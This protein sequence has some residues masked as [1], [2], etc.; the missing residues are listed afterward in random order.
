MHIG[1]GPNDPGT[2]A[3]FVA[4]IDA[5]V[6]DFEHCAALLDPSGAMGTFGIDLLVSA[7]GG[8]P[9]T[10]NVRTVLSGEDFKKCMVAAFQNVEFAHP[11]HGKT[12]L[13][14]SVRIGPR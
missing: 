7:G 13:S 14:Y 2:K 8:H 12:K 3:P 11:K 4:A 5:R 9:Q 1:G 6:H 10:S